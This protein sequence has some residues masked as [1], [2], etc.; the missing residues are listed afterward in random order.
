MF[1]PEAH[2]MKLA[3]AIARQQALTHS[4]RGLS[5]IC[6]IVLWAGS[7]PV[8]LLTR[9]HPKGGGVCQL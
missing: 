3:R 6:E 9:S 5:R 8:R 4:R 2:C 7:L 1:I